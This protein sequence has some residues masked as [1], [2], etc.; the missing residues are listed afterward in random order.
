MNFWKRKKLMIQESKVKRLYEENV[1]HATRYAKAAE[2]LTE[3]EQANSARAARAFHKADK[4]KTRRL[5]ESASS[6]AHQH[7]L[8]GGKLA[9]AQRVKHSTTQAAREKEKAGK[10][11]D[12]LDTREEENMDLKLQVAALQAELQTKVQMAPIGKVNDRFPPDVIFHLWWLLANLVSTMK[13]PEI[14]K[15]V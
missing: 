1:D 3:L 2:K 9:F 7:Q 13:L 12:K 4:E 10:R 5:E 6:I 11:S 14:F 15:L 8:L